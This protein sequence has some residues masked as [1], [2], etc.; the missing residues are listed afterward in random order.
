MALTIHG[1][2]SHRGRDFLPS[3]IISCRPCVKGRVLLELSLSCVKNWDRKGY[4][5]LTDSERGKKDS[6]FSSSRNQVSLS[7]RAYIPAPRQVASEDAGGK[8][9]SKG[10]MALQW[11]GRLSEHSFVHMPMHTMSPCGRYAHLPAQKPACMKVI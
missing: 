2:Y 10:T 6:T 1:R 9:K 5:T 8:G 11:P 7:D 4:P 3:V